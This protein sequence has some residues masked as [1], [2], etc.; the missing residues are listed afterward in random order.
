MCLNFVHCGI[1]RHTAPLVMCQSILGWC[2]YRDPEAD[3]WQHVEAPLFRALDAE[4]VSAIAAQIRATLCTLLQASAAKQPSRWLAAC[5]AIVLASGPAASST[6]GVALHPHR[7]MITDVSAWIMLLQRIPVHSFGM[8]C[9]R[10]CSRYTGRI[11]VGVV[12]HL[13]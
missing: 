2:T 1:A 3:S 13:P 4:N 8:V 9:V 11:L 12:A 7:C 6:A 10:N 5:S